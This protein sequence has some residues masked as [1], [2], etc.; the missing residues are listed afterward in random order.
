MANDLEILEL[1]ISSENYDTGHQFL[2][3]EIERHNVDNIS[4]NDFYWEYMENNIPVVLCNVS[5]H[6]ECRKWIKTPR[7]ASNGCH[8]NPS[9]IFNTP[10]DGTGKSIN[11]DYLKE[12]IGNLMVPT[13]DC[14]REYF[15]SHAKSEMLF[16]DFLN[17]WQQKRED[18]GPTDASNRDKSTDLLYLKDWHLK[19]QR[20]DYNFYD[21]PKHFASDWLNEHL[22]LTESDDYRFVYMG[23]KDTWTPFHSDVFGSFSWS[24]NIMGIK[25]WLLLP[26]GEELKLSDTLGNLPFSI[27]E[28]LLNEHNVRYY[29]LMQSENE[30]LFVPS[31][32]YHQ[33]WNTTDTISVNHNW[34]NACNLKRI[35]FNLSQQMQRVVAE[36]D[37]CRQMD[38]FTEHCQTMLRASFGLN[39]LDFLQLLQ[40]I[41]TRRLGKY[42]NNNTAADLSANPTPPEYTATTTSSKLIFFEHYIPND[43]HIQHDLERILQVVEL[44]LQD[45]VICDD[46][47]V[48]YRKCIQLKESL[49]PSLSSNSKQSLSE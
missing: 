26:P 10:H 28:K 15:N 4:Y 43:Y 13:A 5:K 34:F 8:D 36:I 12:K 27:D 2:P 16:F 24:T 40:T 47:I 41:S 19:A 48:L 25:K 21:V 17:Y 11:Y 9:P 49:I 6:W 33:V 20:M 35:W 14:N 42:N 32:W 30:S 45:S 18:D 1:E 7:D 37:D 39:Y 38:N 46:R 29:T 3:Q 31:G 44:M 22:V 23:P